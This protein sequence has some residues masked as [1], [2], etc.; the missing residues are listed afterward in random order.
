[1]NWTLLILLIISRT[2]AL[3]INEL[4]NWSLP[5]IK[6]L[7]NSP[8]RDF[9]DVDVSSD[10]VDIAVSLKSV[11]EPLSVLVKLVEALLLLFFI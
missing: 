6:S 2:E 1:M 5:A 8:E 4:Q 7:I 11:S 10:F 3:V 9:L